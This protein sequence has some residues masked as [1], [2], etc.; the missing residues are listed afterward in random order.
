[1][2]NCYP[3]FGKHVQSTKAQFTLLL[4]SATVCGNTIRTVTSFPCA[5]QKIC[6]NWYTVQVPDKGKQD[7]SFK[8]LSF[9]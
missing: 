8:N 5:L 2:Q 7:L 3:E 1:M 4:L 9:T 6:Q